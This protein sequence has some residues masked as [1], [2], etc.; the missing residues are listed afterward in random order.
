MEL[1]KYAAALLPHRSLKRICHV[2]IVLKVRGVFSPEQNYSVLEM[3]L[4]YSSA[5]CPKQSN[6]TVAGIAPMCSAYYTEI[7]SFS[8]IW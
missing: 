7:F 1:L 2:A 4:V 8:L 3:L 6:Y 5:A